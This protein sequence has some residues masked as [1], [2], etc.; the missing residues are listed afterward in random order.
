VTQFRDA[1]GDSVYHGFTLHVEKKTSRGLTLQANYTISKG[2]DNA[3]ERFAG[4]SRFIDPNNLKLS[5]AIA[6]Y[7]RP[8]LLVMNYIYELP[9]GQGRTWLR[10]RPVSRVLANW[11][12]S[13][14]TTF[15][16]GLPMVITAP[17]ST[18]LPGVSNFDIGIGRNQRFHEQRINLQ[19]RAELFSAFNH[20]QL[21]SP[22]GSITAPDFGR[23]S[24]AGGTRT[25][26]LGLRLS[27]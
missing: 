3:Q 10:S 25:V 8:H 12:V 19:F 18:Q 2:I 21:G 24:S 20:T 14:I 16:K 22:N 13:G 17:A 27:Y 7:D 11:Q 26:Q 9:F 23:I 15:A 1:V 4:R 5:R 6:E